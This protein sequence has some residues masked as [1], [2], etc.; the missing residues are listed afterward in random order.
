MCEVVCEAM[1][2]SMKWSLHEVNGMR[3]AASGDHGRHQRRKE[4]G[5]LTVQGEKKAVL[6]WTTCPLAQPDP[7]HGI[8]FTS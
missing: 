4:E 6:A 1:P 7:V 3:P 2:P 5:L 8:C